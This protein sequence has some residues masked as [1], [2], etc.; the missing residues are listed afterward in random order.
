MQ[1]KA[2]CTL[3]RAPIA[4]IGSLIAKPRKD[5]FNP[6][7]RISGC[8]G[9]DIDMPTRL[10]AFN[11]SPWRR[12]RLCMLVLVVGVSAILGGCDDSK[13]QQR[14]SSKEKR[15]RGYLEAVVHSKTL[16]EIH[17]RKFDLASIF[18][19]LQLYATMNNGKFPPSLAEAAKEDS[20]L[21]A[22]LAGDD[23]EIAYGYVPG[24]SM[25]SDLGEML[26]YEAQS[27]RDGDRFI[28]RVSG[29]V[30]MLNEEQ[31]EAALSATKP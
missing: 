21:K 8:A 10:S 22:L 26:V 13:K 1:T 11:I 5:M 23:D 17:K 4:S 3:H 29:A 6:Y 2:P 15:Q 7:L 31:F 9:K 28:L 25:Q 18:K 30:D 14:R 27:D 12:V 19:S 24:L 20:S 16:A